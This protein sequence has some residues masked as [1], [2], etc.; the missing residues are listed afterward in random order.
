MKLS[1]KKLSGKKGPR[2]LFGVQVF[3][4]TFALIL[5]LFFTS[6]ANATAGVPLVINFQGRLMDNAGDLLGGPSGT[7]YCY[8][9]SIYDATTGG[10]K[11]WPTGSPS[12]M[13]IVTREGV[14][15][16]SIGDT[17]AGGDALDLAFTDDQA[18]VNVEVAAKVGGSCTTGGDEVFE[19]LSPRPR[20]VSSAFAINSKTVGGFTPAQSA[21]N[22]QIPVLTSGSLILS[23]ATTAGITSSGAN[24]LAVDAGASGVL[25]INGTST[26]DI[27]IGGGSG[28]TGCTITNSS[29]AFACSAGI[30]GTTGT[31]SGAIAANGGITFDAS[32]DTIGAFTAAG[33]IDMNANIIT[34]IGNAGTDFTATGGLTLD[35]I[36]TVNDDLTVALSGNENVE[37]TDGATPTTDILSIIADGAS[38]TNDAN[39]LEIDFT[40]GDGANV[41]QSGLQIDLASGGT[42]SG[43]T[44]YGIHLTMDAADASTQDAIFVNGNFDTILGG[45]TAGTSIFDFT[46]FDVTSAGA[47]SG[48]SLDLTSATQA[49]INLTDSGD[50]SGLGIINFKGGA[51]TRF[52]ILGRNDVTTGNTLT[53]TDGTNELVRITDNGRVGIGSTDPEDLLEVQGAEATDSVLVLDADDGDDAADTWFVKS[54][55]TSNSLSILNDV[56]ERFALTSA[57]NLQFDGT[58]TSGSGNT[59]LT[60]STGMIDADALTLTTAA[61]G[62]TGTS[63]GSGLIVRSDGIGLLQGC[64]DG[65]VLAWVESTD[66]WDCATASG[67]VSDGDKGD[68][69]VSGSGATWTVDYTSSDGVGGTS[70]SGGLEQGTGGIGLLQGCADNEILKWNDGTSVWACATDATSAG[71]GVSTIQEGD[72]TIEGSASTIDFLAADFTV[73]SSPAGEANIVIDYTNSGITRNSQ[74][75]AIT[76]DWGFTLGAGEAIDF[77]AGAA[78]TV[79]MVEIGNTGQGTTTTGVDGLEINF[80]TAAVAGSVEN[81]AL[82]IILDPSGATEA[83]DQVNAVDIANITNPTGLTTGVR[84]G[85]GYDVGIAFRDSAGDYVGFKAPADVTTTTTWTLPAADA[86]GCFK[87]DGSGNMSISSC[88]D[89][90]VQVYDSNTT[91]TVP[92]DAQM[93]IIE[94]IGGGGSGGGGALG[95]I[96]QVAGGGGGGGGAYYLGTFAVSDLGGAN[97]VLQITRGAGGSSPNLTVDGNSGGASCVSTSSSCGGTVYHRAYGGGGGSASA[98]NTANGGGGGG[99]GGG[100]TSAGNNAAAANRVGGTGGLPGPAAVGIASDGLGGGGG[101]TGAGTGADGGNSGWGGAGG[102]ASSTN[103]AATTGRGGNSARGGAGGG[104]GASCTISPCTTARVGQIGGSGGNGQFAG[105]AG[106]TA[107]GGD[108]SAGTNAAANSA[109]GGGGGGGGGSNQAASGVPGDGGAGGVPG[110]G[111]G[112]GGT[113]INNTACAANCQGTGGAGG[114][115]RVRITT[116]RGAGADLAEMYATND[117]E[118]KAG[119]VVALDPELKAGVKKTTRA[120]DPNVIGVIS[121][122]PGITIGNIDQDPTARPVLLALAGR[123]PVKVSMENGP[124][125]PGDLLTPSSV[126]GVAMKST[127]AGIIIGQALTKFDQ[128]IV[129]LGDAPHPTGYLMMF[130]KNSYANGSTLAQVIPGLELSDG[131]PIATEEDNNIPSENDAGVANSEADTDPPE[132]EEGSTELPIPE[133]TAKNDVGIFALKYFMDKKG[134]LSES[135]SFSEVMADR[136]SA[137]LE[138]ITP[139]LTADTVRTNTITTSTGKDINLVLGPDGKFVIGGS[140]EVTTNEDGSTSTI[141]TEPPVITFDSLGNAIFAGK[142]TANEIS[143]NSVEGIQSIIAQ[144]SQLSQGQA[145]LTLTA[146]A[147]DALTLALEESKNKILGLETTTTDLATRL[148]VI[149]VMLNANAFDA[150]TSLTTGNLAVSGD[151]TYTGQAQFDGLSFFNNE[152]KF[153]GLVT[154]DQEVEF[155]APPLFNKDTAGFALIHEG[156]RRVSVTFDKPYVMTPIV[157][158]SMSFETTDNIDDVSAMSLFDSDI[159]FV[160]LDKSNTGFTILL[161]QNAPMNIRFSWIA[162]GVRDPKIIE[163]I[164]EGLVINPPETNDDTI[165]IPIPVPNNNP[166]PSPEVVPLENPSGGV[167]IPPTGDTTGGVI[168]DSTSTEEIVPEPEPEVEDSSE[169]PAPESSADSSSPDGGSTAP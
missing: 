130:I 135:V 114:N 86:A 8:K 103:G 162:L 51:T 41:T 160:T 73:T 149:E 48:L 138:V 142:I 46:N 145:G 24:P 5:N 52:Q 68:V 43:D 156:D 69:T 92:A 108:G 93:I 42:A 49:T 32:T 126:P 25:N 29:G 119:D 161:N 21:T 134:E 94:A 22:N 84:V 78:P 125:N 95:N 91:Y 35:D 27:L 107:P 14:F 13:T 105:G 90:K 79:D 50:T 102:G 9:F 157:N 152:A 137:G 30:S 169:P 31:F 141:E 17:G 99:G 158:V 26:G 136:V 106:G 87:S 74:N 146:S 65:Q 59:V 115:G 2:M 139:T 165:P 85:S 23:H 62:G 57:G 120:Y 101:A 128:S 60:L 140:S 18:Y 100:A 97:S 6:F 109:F 151:S 163:S 66:T 159:R 37:I 56:T 34:N 144:L 64:T 154:F 36:L 1:N 111:G 33:T 80:V 55:A 104:G 132:S 155:K 20:I 12:T 54:V 164:A 83:G 123:V 19:T 15:D 71:A 70:T 81:S 28:S 67:G 124:I 147:L 61:D 113:A 167:E 131:P 117:D 133:V 122:D 143:I 47:I 63:S 44:I 40:T 166:A 72:S 112:G 118:L 150:L 88:G 110:G 45:T 10:S 77:V 98:N 129:D 168:E 38:I 148:G 153:S 127:K 121:T 75:E 82:E 7:D 96:A 3:F 116:L 16:A 39:A 11:I 53:F 58:L 4:I 89:T 76:G